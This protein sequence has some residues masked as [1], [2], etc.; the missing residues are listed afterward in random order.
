MTD[1]PNDASTFGASSAAEEP[2]V[3]KRVRR[4]Q[5][6]L[7]ELHGQPVATHIETYDAVHAE[8]QDAL[9]ELDEA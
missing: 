7:E 5:Q 3:A 1:R 9:A 4:A 6:R 2:D 8:L